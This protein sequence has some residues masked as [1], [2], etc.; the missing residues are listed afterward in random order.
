MDQ[1]SAIHSMSIGEKETIFISQM[2]G[3]SI[4]S[5]GLLTYI[6]E[7]DRTSK[8]YCKTERKGEWN[9]AEQNGIE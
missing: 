8:A 3:K 6:V 5:M 1:M 9:G 4:T 7:R 2:M